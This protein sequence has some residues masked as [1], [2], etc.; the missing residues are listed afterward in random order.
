MKYSSVLMLFFFSLVPATSYAQLDEDA[1]ELLELDLE[2]LGNIVYSASR[3]LI[4][5]DESP[6]AFSVITA[7]DIK[8]RGYKTLYEVLDEVPGFYNT[9]VAAWG[10]T[11]NRGVAGDDNAGY[12][13]LIDGH[14]ASNAFRRG[15]NEWYRF[16]LLANVERIEVLRGA[17]STLWGSY[18]TKGIIHIFTKSGSA[19]DQDD[20]EKG[21]AVVSYDYEFEHQRHIADILYGKQFGDDH[22]LMIS[23]NY[24]DSDAPWKEGRIALEDGLAQPPWLWFTYNQWD[25]E[26]S[27]DF[28]AQYRRRDL[29]VM[30]KL[31]RHE[32]LSPLAT[33][34]DKSSSG[35]QL[36]ELNWLELKYAPQLTSDWKFESRLYIDDL[37][38]ELRGTNVE[39]GAESSGE[40]EDI[41]VGMEHIL[42]YTGFNEQRLLFGLLAERSRFT[43]T[44]PAIDSKENN[45][46][47]FIEDRYTG[48]DNMIFTLGGRWSGLRGDHIESSSSFTPR[49][50]AI[51]LSPADWVLEYSYSTGIS[52]MGHAFSGEK[53]P[54]LHGDIAYRI[55]TDTPMK[56]EVHDLQWSLRKEGLYTAVTLY[57]QV[58]ENI[59][60]FL[61]GSPV[62]GQIDG[63]PLL[64]GLWDVG[65]VHSKGVELEF[66]KTLSDILSLYGNLAWKDSHWEDTGFLQAT[67]LVDNGDGTT[68]VPEFTWNLGIDYDYKERLTLNVK[69]RGWDNMAFITSSSRQS[70]L[71]FNEPKAVEVRGPEHYV[72]LNILW[73]GPGRS[74][75][76]FY[77]KNLFDNDSALAHINSGE[78]DQPLGRQVGVSAKVAF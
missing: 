69:Y 48:I 65:H 32:Y 75:F 10:L 43:Y 78:L 8:R 9:G 68:T 24:S 21:R 4:P 42:A 22:E 20:A 6:G 54:I 47:F 52:Q 19:I 34:F 59:Y 49:F 17:A 57:S 12:L 51:Y 7:D 2:Q 27:H 35:T 16:P 67:N 58:V 70:F 18:A 15:V 14:S 31:N 61:T 46:A 30:A 73:A 77:V 63:L 1:Q 44:S 26:P 5:I 36:S 29:T 53:N 11:T 33:P 55:S 64:R 50:S 25:Y 72:D 40:W 3:S 23:L 71:V 39:T 45:G 38:S 74:E 37:F 76:S 28:Y 56:S 13:F 62:I 60:G 41:L 66:E